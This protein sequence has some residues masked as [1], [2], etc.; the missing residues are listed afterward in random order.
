[1]KLPNNY[2]K[3]LKHKL[4][5]FASNYAGL[6]ELIGHSVDLETDEV[7][8]EALKKFL[9]GKIGIN[10]NTIKKFYEIN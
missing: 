5:K 2:E 6:Q 4:F 1:M 9:I 8:T 3:Y 7:N 10:P